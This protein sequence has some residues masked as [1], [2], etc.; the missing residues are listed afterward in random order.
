MKTVNYI[1]LY[2]TFY[3]QYKIDCHYYATKN[4]FFELL[5]A[6][7]LHPYIVYHTY[8]ED[9]ENKEYRLWI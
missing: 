7:E 4:Q 3:M 2:E 6:C 9:L 1:G 8:D 5:D